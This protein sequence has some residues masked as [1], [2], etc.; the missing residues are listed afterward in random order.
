MD[1][2]V[3]DSVLVKPVKS[4]PH[5][6]LWVSNID[7]VMVRF[8]SAIAYIYRSPPNGDSDHVAEILRDALSKVLVDFYPLAGRLIL[9]ASGRIAVDCNGEGALFVEAETDFTID[10]FGDFTSPSQL[11]TLVPSATYE[12]GFTTF[13]LLMVQV[14]KFKC[15]GV[16]LGTGIQH[17]LSDGTSSLHFVN[18]WCDV[19]RG[20]QLHLLPQIDRTPLRARDPPRVSFSHEEFVPPPTLLHQ[21]NHI[22]QEE[23]NKVLF[24]RFNLSK[25]QVKS[26]K[27]KA[28]ENPLNKTYSTY[29]SLAAHIWKCCTTARGLLE[30]Q[31]CKLYIPV[32]GRD[33]L[34]K[35]PL[36]RG[37]FGNAIFMATPIET[38]GE[39][40]SNPLWY[41]AGKIQ[42]SI[43]KMDDEYLRSGLDFLESQPD[44]N[45]FVRSRN[46][47]NCP[48][49]VI[50]SW[51]S[52]P[53]YDADF[54]W[55]RPTMLGPA[56][57]PPDGLCRILPIP[58]NDGS[59]SVCLGLLNDH[60]V[61]FGKLLYE[62]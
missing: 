57:N 40:V 11:T 41:S 20:L 35:P 61:K 31:R 1:V 55:G 8:H 12:N 56:E 7:L 48:N 2:K 14:T 28:S 9:D 43:G 16:A 18:S 38:A 26:I 4:T 6:K 10:D 32:D 33:R 15:G 45:A 25:E 47:F 39:I 49:M 21:E 51:T 13:P 53:F 52:L 42:E 22:L 30:K 54:G 27:D 50:N 34:C 23:S 5:H 44:L 62:F 46:V 17:I 37:Y 29:V 36:P 3:T 60:L 19:A 24:G 58:T 59:V